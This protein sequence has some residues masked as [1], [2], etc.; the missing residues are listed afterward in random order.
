MDGTDK[1]L[2][3]GVLEEDGGSSS[4]ELTEGYQSIPG[5]P[6]PAASAAEGCSYLLPLVQDHRAWRGHSAPGGLAEELM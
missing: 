2:L 5:K 6:C 4:Q 1:S 3:S